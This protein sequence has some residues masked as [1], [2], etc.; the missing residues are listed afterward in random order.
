MEIH[1][2]KRATEESSKNIPLTHINRKNS[3]Q[4]IMMLLV[5]KHEDNAEK[6]RSRVNDDFK[7]HYRILCHEWTFDWQI[8]F[9]IQ[10]Q[11]PWHD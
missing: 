4:N 10:I 11:L 3:N 7:N 5:S 9:N 8:R 1:E 2:K 6:K